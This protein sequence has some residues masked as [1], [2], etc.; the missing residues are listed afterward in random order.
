MFLP[1]L[2]L[3]LVSLHLNY[4]H[5]N[6]L[7]VVP[8]YSQATIMPHTDIY[9]SRIYP[10]ILFKD[11]VACLILLIV[12]TG[13][14]CYSPEYFSNFINNAPVEEGVTPPHIIPEWYFLAFYGMLKLFVSKS[15]GVCCMVG[16]IVIP[17]FL[18][19]IVK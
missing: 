2:V 8:L 10:D 12:V 6:K 11:S 7:T 18:P 9:L 3:G 4:I 1:F 19:I 16:C 15:L 5:T 13:F 14:I 17:M